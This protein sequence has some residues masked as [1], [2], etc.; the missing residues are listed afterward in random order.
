MEEL[1]EE[2][3]NLLKPREYKPHTPTLIKVFG[4][5][6]SPIID[7]NLFRIAEASK[8]GT[9]YDSSAYKE[10]TPTVVKVAGVVKDIVQEA[11]P[12]KIIKHF[13]K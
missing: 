1:L 4:T 6:A 10:G 9:G 13:W 2:S 11:A 12:V 8:T 7:N 5:L 3:Q